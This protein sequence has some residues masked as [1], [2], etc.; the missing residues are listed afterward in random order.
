MET[1]KKESKA[2]DLENLDELYKQFEMK[3]EIE[4]KVLGLTKEMENTESIL[5]MEELKS[6]RRV[7]RRLGYTSETDVIQTKGRVACEI[8]AGDELVLTELI[9]NGAF[10]N[11]TTEQTCA[12]LSCFT[13]SETTKTNDNLTQPELLEPFKL[14]KQTA[15]T[16]AEISRDSKIDLNTE[17]Y[18]ESFKFEL[19]PVVYA[20]SLGAKF[21]QICKLTDVFEGSIIRSVRRLEEL[22]Q[23]LIVA[24]R[25]IGNSELEQ[26][27]EKCT[28]FN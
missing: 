7:L 10:A 8:S 12:L 9:F 16:I 25:G 27:F 11:L 28:N 2:N 18:V 6:R 20:W 26:K 14:L 24:S 19:M 22:L 13:F 23:Q 5:Q 4:G 3:M 21:S 17:E 1:K 15:T